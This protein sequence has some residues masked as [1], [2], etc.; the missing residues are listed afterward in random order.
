M[1]VS[2]WARA[3]GWTLEGCKTELEDLAL[4]IDRALKTNGFETMDRGRFAVVSSE[5]PDA[6]QGE[7]TVQGDDLILEK[8]LK[9]ARG[10]LQ[11]LYRQEVR[12]LVGLTLDP[13]TQLYNSAGDPPD[14]SAD[15]LPHSVAALNSLEKYRDS[16]LS[17]SITAQVAGGFMDIIDSIVEEGSSISLLASEVRSRA[18]DLA[19]TVKSLGRIHQ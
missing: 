14:Y 4:T 11:G 18:V 12:R 16:L 10:I 17:S 2:Q 15:L 13:G 19:T 1:R 5:G 9:T 6:S 8:N 3:E 7:L